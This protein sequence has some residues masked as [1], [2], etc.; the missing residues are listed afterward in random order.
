MA[1]LAQLLKDPP[2]SYVFELSEAGIAFAKIGPEPQINFQPLEEGCFRYRRCTTISKS[3][4]Y[5]PP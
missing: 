1:A 2:P 5:F 3:R 4:N